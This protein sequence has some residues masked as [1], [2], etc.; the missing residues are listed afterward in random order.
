MEIRRKGDQQGWVG[1]LGGSAEPAKRSTGS[2]GRG[3]RSCSPDRKIQMGYLPHEKKKALR[4]KT[5]FRKL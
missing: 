4:K 1:V 2:K 5:N 3:T